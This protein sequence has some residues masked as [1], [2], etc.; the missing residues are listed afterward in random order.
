VT[1]DLAKDYLHDQLR[2]TRQALIWKLDGL[3]EYEV[4]RPLTAT[5]TNL[6]GLVKHM[7][8]WEVRYLGEVFDR[9]FTEPMPRWQ[10]ADGS[11]LWVTPD[12]TRGQ[13]IDFYRRAWVHADTTIKELP[14]DAPGHVPWWPRPDVKLFTIMVHVLQDTTRHAGHADILR[15]QLDGR[16][17]VTAEYEEQIDTAARAAY[18]AT[19]ERA[20]QEA[21]DGS[22]HADLSDTHRAAGTP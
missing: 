19:I 10:D 12:E 8:T 7:A 9:P 1:D 21:V 3:P 2:S 16:T 14:I 11:D 18:R 5:G 13:I 20:A 4:R 17:G 6:L 15:E 22:H